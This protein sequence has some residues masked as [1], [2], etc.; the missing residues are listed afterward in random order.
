MSALSAIRLPIAALAFLFVITPVWAAEAPAAA[1]NGAAFPKKIACKVRAAYRKNADGKPC[2]EVVV[3]FL[4]GKVSDDLEV[5]V[6]TEDG[7]HK[8]TL[9]TFKLAGLKNASAVVVTLPPGV[10]IEKD[11]QAKILLPH[12]VTPLSDQVDVPKARLWTVYL[13]PHSHVDI[14]YTNTQKN[15]EI[16]H[17]NNIREGIK[18]GEETQDLPAGARSV[19]NPEV[20]WPLERLW[21]ES[22]AAAREKIIAA[23][24][25]GALCVDASYL[26]VDTSAACDEEYF[27][28]FAFSRKM[29]KATGVPMDVFQQMDVPG[30]SWGVVPIM[31][32]LGVKYIMAWPNFERAEPAHKELDGRPLWWVGPDGRSKVLFFQPG[33]YANSGSMKKGEQIKRPW[34]GHR[35][36]TKVPLRIQSGF[37]DVDFSEQCAQMER[38]DFPYDFLV[39]SW[40]LWDNNP[41]D[42]DVPA[43]VAKWNATHVSPRIVISGGHAIMEMIERKYGDKLPTVSGDYTEYWTDGLGTAAGLTAKNRATKERLVQIET[44]RSMLGAGKPAPRAELDEAWRYASLGSEHTWCTENPSGPF[45]QDR[46]FKVKTRYFREADERSR[47]LLDEALAPATDKSEGWFDDHNW[48]SGQPPI[49]GGPSQGGVAVFNTLSFP[50]GGAVTLS[51]AESRQGDRVVDAQGREAPSQ[52]L[53][54]GEL[55]FVA[56]HVPPLASAHFTVTKGKGSVMNQSED[57]AYVTPGKAGPVLGNGLLDVE[58]DSKTGNI[59]RVWDVRLKRNFVD[60]KKDGGLNA[61]RWL[62]GFDPKDAQADRDARIEVIENGPV[63]VELRVT[64]KAPG[65]RSLVRAVRL[66]RGQKY[67]ECRNT[68]DKLPLTDKDGVHFG[69]A[70]DLPGS[71]THVDLPWAVME[72]EKDQWKQ[73]N[74]NWL[75]VQRWLDLSND[76]AGVT[77]C[78]LD[79]PLFEC[80]S[81]TACLTGITFGQYHGQFAEKIAPHA[82]IYSWVMNNHWHTNFPLTQDGPVTFRYRLMPHAGSFDAAAANRFG[83]AQ[84]QPL[85]PILA[86]VNPAPRSAVA[87]DNPRVVATVLRAE[88]DGSRTLRLRSLS[89]KEEVVNL[90]FP[91]GAP[92][93]IRGVTIY[94]DAGE[95]V[96]RPVKLPP[97]GCC[98]LRLVAKE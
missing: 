29:Q 4:G 35:D 42:A 18:L 2:R 71:R 67:V 6:Q 23:I 65:C 9:E 31:A 85:T 95:V 79:A 53:S 24:K 44:L 87:L 77:W 46:I 11:A 68:V 96:P 70:F 51:R 37:A 66:V 1:E 83:L 22:D 64:S 80:G 98:S 33:C 14:G 69:F 7:V 13:Y 43:A 84:M 88:E 34:F 3:N 5:H 48:P 39:L 61:F 62:P 56:D 90:S 10:G 58:L 94:G 74:R 93:A 12:A 59:I 21:I 16:L 38:P 54:T 49:P 26:N 27:H 40:S 36:P 78:S 41:I 17:K 50:R 91:A 86:K 25:G 55:V 20:T 72:V 8:S 52:R 73:A 45:F 97:F 89:D 63:V 47:E 28:F 15:V 75:M 92:K 81:L 60:V 76:E 32:Q 19:W 57:W 30:F 82:N